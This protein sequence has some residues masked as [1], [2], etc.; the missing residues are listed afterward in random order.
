MENKD[1]SEIR[2]SK[3]YKIDYDHIDVA[4]IMGQVRDKV[5]REPVP[6]P[7]EAG[8]PGPEF[9]PAGLPPQGPL[10]LKKKVKKGFK[11]TGDVLLE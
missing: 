10:S 3:T 1:T 11:V 8:G 9:S 4:Q 5:A 2:Y 7:P 6:A